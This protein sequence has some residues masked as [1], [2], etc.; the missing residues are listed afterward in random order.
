MGWTVMAFTWRQVI[1]EPKRVI[2]QIRRAL[3]LP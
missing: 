3:G 2:R 1:D